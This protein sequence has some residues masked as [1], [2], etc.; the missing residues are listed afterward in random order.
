M[1]FSLTLFLMCSLPRAHVLYTNINLTS[2][3][4]HAV[5]WKPNHGNWMSIYHFQPIMF[6]SKVYDCKGLGFEE[7]EIRQPQSPCQTVARVCLG[8][9]DLRCKIEAL[10]TSN[11]NGTRTAS[12]CLGCTVFNSI[13]MPPFS[14]Q[15]TF[16]AWETPCAYQGESH[17]AR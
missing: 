2:Q 13:W 1:W 3:K 8:A 7:H 12:G 9:A 4:A 14:Q 11:A 17:I 10:R 5:K 16:T 6:K 15:K